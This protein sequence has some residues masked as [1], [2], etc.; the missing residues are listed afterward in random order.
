MRTV[1]AAL[2]IALL[3]GMGVGSGGLLVIYLTLIEGIPQLSAQGANL[4]FF[5]FA[6]AASL[7]VHAIKRKLFGGAVLIM[8]ASGVVGSLAGSLI[9]PLLPA[10]L[11]G[12]IFGAMLVITG[13]FSLRRNRQSKRERKN[14]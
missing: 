14:M 4:L 5:T 2:A 1:I 8:G 9:A 13:I 10:P 12:K 7:I 3:S 6:S 11:L